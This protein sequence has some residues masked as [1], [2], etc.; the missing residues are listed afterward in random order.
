MNLTQGLHRA[1]QNHPDRMATIFGERQQS[2]QQMAERVARLA[3]ALRSL[4]LGAN[5]RIAMLALNSDRYV[6]YFQAAWWAGAVANP[7][8]TRWSLSEIAYSLN[9]CDSQV[10]IVDDQFAGMV[11]AI[12]EQAPCVRTII[13]AGEQATPPGMLGYEELIAAAAPVEDAMRGGDDLAAILYTGGTTGFPKGVMLSH[14]NFWIA[15]IA[16]MAEMGG[17]PGSISLIATPL[18]HVGG[19]GRLVG[20]SIGGN[21]VVIVPSFTAE[22][23]LDAVERHAVTDLMLVPTM[24]Q[25]LLD[26]PRFERRKMATIRRI[27]YG[28]SPISLPLL[29]R[30]LDLFPGVEFASAYGMTETA[31]AVCGNPPANHGPEARASGL[32][33]SVGRAGYGCEIRVVDADGEEVPRGAVGEVIIRGGC[34]M[35]GYWKKPEETAAAL[36]G[37]WLHTGDGGYLDADG[38]LYIVDRIKDMIV[39]GGENVYSAEVEN[40]LARH[41]AVA[42]CAVIGIPSAQWGESVHAVVVLR[43]G[44]QAREDDL[45]S[46]CKTALAGYK[47]PK[48]FDFPEAMPLSAAGKVVKTQLR[49]PYWRGQSR[50]VN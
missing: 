34:V 38:H 41:P 11:D 32:V 12:R 42:M 49:E 48:S 43:T 21:T 36:R 33:K 46:H 23:V 16:R 31:A 18:F 5:D 13:H 10:L 14:A 24:L 47:C 19:A 30:T 25:M 27:S 44:A 29:E 37:G 7:V 39:T 35:L 28:A 2:F 17:Q 1:R 4:G 45:R 8:N 22:G 3:G 15:S 26:H 20:Q 50:K 9:D 40:V 6:E